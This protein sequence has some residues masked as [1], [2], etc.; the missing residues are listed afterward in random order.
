[1][2]TTASRSTARIYEI[3]SRLR[4]EY[5]QPRHHNPTDPLD[6][7]IF[8]VL[9]RMTQETKYVRTYR[10]LREHYPSWDLVREAPRPSV[11]QLLHDAG[12]APTKAKQIK[13]ILDEILAREGELNLDRLEQL[14]DDEAERYLTSLPGVSLK[15]AR[16]VLLYALDREKLPVDAHVWR[17][18]KRLGL[19]PSKPW[20]EAGG[21]A[22]E[23]DVPAPLRASLHV[24]LLAHGR[25][26]CRARVPRC[27]GCCVLD[28][29]PHGQDQVAAAGDQIA[30]PE[31][32]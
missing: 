27:E 22:L 11:E 17:I 25:A 30:Q 12:P 7:L 32:R 9:S 10:G 14:E 15:T 8:L 29:C 16:C 13:E 24:T 18:A 28:L 21:R 23:T 4:S 31:K 3:E 19:A 1:M 2:P 5:G 6:D 20:S 26:V